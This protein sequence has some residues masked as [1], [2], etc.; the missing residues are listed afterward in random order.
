MRKLGP[1]ATPEQIRDYIETLHGFAG[2]SGVYDFRAG[3][4]HGI[5]EN[6]VVMVRW[7]PG[8]DTF[9]AVSKR[10]GHLK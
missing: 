1:S 2:V 3:D 9:V 7:N 4:Q 5:G 8:N 6:G 10:S